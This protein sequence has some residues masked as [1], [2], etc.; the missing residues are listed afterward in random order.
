MRGGKRGTGA[1]QRMPNAEEIFAARAES[2]TVRRA[3]ARCAGCMLTMGKHE[4]IRSPETEQTF[5]S[6][7]WASMITPV[8]GMH[9]RADKLDS[10]YRSRYGIGFQDYG[11]LYLAQSGLCCICKAVPEKPLVVDHDHE[12]GEVRGL[13]CGLCN[14]GLGM[15]KDNIGAMASAITYLSRT[16]S[17]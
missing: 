13:L 6:P 17:A 4:V 16:R 3:K 7:C 1:I 12:S 14:S 15:F 10:Y 5:C 11:A 8:L 9:A 2:I